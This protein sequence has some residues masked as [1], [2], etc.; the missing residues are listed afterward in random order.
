MILNLGKRELS[1]VI[2]G[3]ELHKLGWLGWFIRKKLTE[4]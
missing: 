2:E 3:F 1:S 4:I